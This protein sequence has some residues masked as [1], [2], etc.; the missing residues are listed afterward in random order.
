MQCPKCSKQARRSENATCTECGYAFGLDP[1]EPH[2]L[3]DLDLLKLAH[4]ASSGGR[5]HF[6]QNLL[7]V[8]YCM[9]RVPMKAL[10]PVAAVLGGVLGYQLMGSRAAV[11]GAAAAAG[12]VYHGTKSWRPPPPSVLDDVYDQMSAA[13]HRL[14]RFISRPLFEFRDEDKYV[15]HLPRAIDVDNVIVV[16]RN[17]LVDWLVLNDLP[18]SLNALV[19]SQSGYPNYVLPIAIDLLNLR[20]SIGIYLLHDSTQS[21][22]AMRKQ[23]ADSGLLPTAGHRMFNLGIEPDQVTYMK[24]LDPIQPS[25]TRFRIPLDSI[26]FPILERALYTSIKR[27]VPLLTGFAAAGWVGREG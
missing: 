19:I 5:H 6:T 2:G 17:G 15:D 8:C 24:H 26:P 7:Y 1:R 27:A 21:S 3:T 13:G 12:L 14:P 10:W 20:K 4:Q 18:R 22:L 25:R 11:M 23:L 16:D 9:E